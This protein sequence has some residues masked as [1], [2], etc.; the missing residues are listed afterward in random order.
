MTALSPANA[1][2]HLPPNLNHWYPVAQSGELKTLK[3]LAVTVWK[4]SIV[5]FRNS[6]RQVR[7]IEDRCPHRQVKLSH[8]DVQGDRIVCAYHGWEFDGSGRCQSVPYL[9]GGQGMPSGCHVRAYPVREQDG[10]IWVFPGSPEQAETVDPMPIPQWHSLSHIVSWASMDCEAHYAFLIENLMDM[11]HGH[12]HRHYQAWLNP[13]LDTIDIDSTRIIA[14]YR[15]D[16]V[17]RIRSLFSALQLVI[18]ALRRPYPT[19]LTVSYHYPHWLARLGEDFSLCCLFSPIDETRTRIHFMHFTNLE[20]FPV[21]DAPRWVQRLIKRSFRNSAR[22][23]IHGLLRDD[24]VMVYEEQ[25]AHLQHPRLQNIELNPA[26]A[27]VQRLI[28][29]Q[30][31]VSAG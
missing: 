3:A 31:G 8:G 12:L 10:F 15:A 27:A 25:Q 23:M 24:A 30:A 4:Q 22:F 6:Q 19:H 29:Q 7:A 28:R 21:R 1:T 5:L 11:Y 13:H 16:C 18:P 26:L 14:R 17:F 20:R 2:R 9:T